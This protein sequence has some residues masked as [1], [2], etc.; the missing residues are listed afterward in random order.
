MSLNAYATPLHL[1]VVP[2]R[3]VT[4]YIVVV[5]VLCT[6]CVLLLPVPLFSK[7]LLLILFV[8]SA[9]YYLLK[10]RMKLGQCINRLVWTEGNDWMLGSIDGQ[11]QAASLLGNTYVHPLMTVLLFSTENSWRSR[12]VIL[13]PDNT[14]KQGFRRLR[15]RL[16]LQRGR[17]FDKRQIDK[18]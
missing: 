6:V 1:D 14:P 12:P 3:I 2:S 7:P 9:V 10:V 13:L 16:K 15:V 11:V 4:V 17:L 8:A 18:N 5:H